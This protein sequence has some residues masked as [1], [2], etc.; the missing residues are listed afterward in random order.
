MDTKTYRVKV[1]T[2][3]LKINRE[4]LEKRALGL[5]LLPSSIEELTDQELDRLV[6]LQE[7]KDY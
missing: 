2:P 6:M 1:G 7:L 4:L 5:G 3:N